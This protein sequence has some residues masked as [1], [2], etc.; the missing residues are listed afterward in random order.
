MK[1]VVPRRKFS[2]AWSEIEDVIRESLPSCVKIMLSESGYD[3]LLSINSI[4]ESIMFELEH[5]VNKNRDIIAKLDCCFAQTYKS[6]GIFRF[7]PA[8]RLLILRLPFYVNKIFGPNRAASTQ[9][10]K[11]IGTGARKDTSD[12]SFLLSLLSLLR[13]MRVFRKHDIDMMKHFD[14]FQLTFFYAAV[15]LAMRY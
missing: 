13:K 12:Y 2:P 11:I 6:L 9:Q 10:H 5:F 8:H 1:A 3:S 4:N 14:C 7:L 15:D